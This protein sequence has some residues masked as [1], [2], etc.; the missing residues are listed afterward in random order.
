MIDLGNLFCR[1]FTSAAIHPFDTSAWER[2]SSVLR[3]KDGRA[4]K[5]TAGVEVP[6]FWSQ[7]ATDMLA[8]KYFRKAGVPAATR[9]SKGLSIEVPEWLRPRSPLEGTTFGGETSAKQ[10]F[11]RLAGHWTFT[12]WKHGFFKD[13]DEYARTFFDE[14]LYMLMHQMAAPNSP[15]WF[16]TGLWWA[17]GIEGIPT[18][19]WRVAEDETGTIIPVPVDYSFKHPQVHACF[20]QS[21]ED[22]LVGED[23]IFGLWTREAR[24]F[25]F[26]GGSGTNFSEIRGKSEPLSGGGFSSGLMSWLRIGDRAAGAIK[27]GGTTRR[28]AKMVIVDADHPD[29]VDF[30]RWKPEEEKK[31]AALICGYQNLHERMQ[32]IIRGEA[33]AVEAA[34]LA[35]VPDSYILK[36][37]DMKKFGLS[38]SMEELTADFEGEAYNTVSGQNGNNSVRIPNAFMR[39]LQEDKLWNLYGR[40]EKRRAADHDE[41]PTPMKTIPARQL[42]QEIVNAAWFCSDP[43]IIFETLMNAWNTCPVDGEIRATNPC[44][45]YCFLD[46]TACNLASLNLVR[47][48]QNK[49]DFD[50]EG[51]IHAVRMWTVIL[52]ITIDMAGY[53]SREI[54]RR[55]H[56]Y[57]TLG[58]GYANLGALLMLMGHPYDSDGGREIASCVTSLMTATAYETSSWLA[59]Y[60]G[61]FPRFDANR[62]HVLSVLQ[63]HATCSGAHPM[64][65]WWDERFP[66]DYVPQC[67]VGRGG[68]QEVVKN[69]WSNCVTDAYNWGVRNAQATLVAPTG[70]ISLVMD[71]DTTGV[72]PDFAAVKFKKLAGG[73]Y[74][75][76]VNQ[77]IPRSLDE[78]GYEAWQIRDI[79]QYMLGSG[80]LVDAPHGFHRLVND[81]GLGLV[82]GMLK[83]CMDVRMLIEDWQTWGYTDKQW[84]E[85]NTA[86]CGT[87]TIEGAPHLHASH[88]PIFDCASRC[89][90]KGQRYIAPKAHVSMMAA[91]QPYISGAIS[92][93]INMPSESSVEDVDSILLYAWQRGVKDIAL[94]RDTSK[95]SQPLTADVRVDVSN[96]VDLTLNVVDSVTYGQRRQLP[97]RRLG[98]TQKVQI[99]RHK[100]YFRTG[101]YEDGT[102]GEIFIDM[103]K[104]GSQ[105]R[106]WANSFA[107]AVSIGLQHGVPLQR[108]IS[109]FLHTKSEPNGIVAGHD[110]IRMCTSVPDMIFRDLGLTYLNMTEL[111]HVPPSQ[112]SHPEGPKS[113]DYENNGESHGDEAMVLS[114]YSVSEMV[115]DAYIARMKGYEGESC[116]ECHQMTLVRSGTC[117]K[118][119]TCGMTTG[120]N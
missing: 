46:D 118:C 45:E 2:R 87:M 55:S 116:S 16:N 106:F 112:A 49:N 57:R 92:K 27:S 1:H 99:A 25:K 117:L 4:L 22:D 72:E 3:D 81:K 101:E 14:V 56:L 60:L 54:A 43:G 120:C 119:D 105:L 107:M 73:G 61:S 68:L 115:A 84:D 74:L 80:T 19:T 95:L 38:W 91:V 18:G 12:G 71:C 114:G 33:G 62:H 47:F 53:P 77:S 103:A 36:A 69:A 76:I 58:L 64:G 39:K 48:F 104:D 9:P 20:I 5:E 108:F 40:L 66:D 7:T 50:T 110:N 86:I 100:V 41:T 83:D 102:L 44:A 63:A 17:Y 98:Y 89:G 75:K 26:G 37:L 42:W 28:A 70:T 85:I 67:I 94:Y 13:E 24:V 34:K 23:G 88:L 35:R 97:S 59:S 29:I 111:A 52:D 11:T 30:I 82:E 32:A 96:L 79:E 31:V 10:V 15:Q 90:R 65:E 8:Q 6:A 78:L 93:T 109:T 51:F 113:H 21:V